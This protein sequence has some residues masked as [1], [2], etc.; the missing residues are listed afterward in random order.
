VGIDPGEL[1]ALEQR[2]ADRRHLGAPPGV[3]AVVVLPTHH[4]LT[5]ILPM[6]G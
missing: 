1:G 2:V 5:A 3:R 4:D 6:S